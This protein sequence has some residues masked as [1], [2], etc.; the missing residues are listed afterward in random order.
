MME[1]KTKRVLVTG[2]SGF[3]G[4]HLVDR[5]VTLGARVAVVD[6]LEHPERLKRFEGQLTYTAADL[7]D[8]KWEQGE[9]APFEIIFHLAAFSTPSAA[10]RDPQLAYRQNVMATANMLQLA[11]QC[12]VQKFVFSSAGALYTNLPKYLPID[13]Q[14]PIDPCQSVYAMTK[15][16][17][18]LLCE[19]FHR[20]YQVPT[21]YFRLFN[22]YGPLQADHFLI[23]SF[24]REA[25]TKGQVTVLNGAVR[26]D[27]TY[28][29]DTVKAL[30][31]GA[32]SEFCGG[33]INL[34]TGV[35]TS[36]EEIARAIGTSL[37]VEVKL[38]NRQV[39]GPIRQ[40]CDRR[41]AERLLGWEPCYSLEQGLSL[42]LQSAHMP[43]A[44]GGRR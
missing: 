29:S 24:I 30:L 40:L 11:R 27:F 17:G 2:G 28:V 31:L 20:Q 12:G 8:W 41:L 23:P 25:L 14:H 21:V 44:L 32:E 6:C 19:D 39:F 7:A 16:I 4:S 38:L 18:E 42:T 1:W 9:D 15:R 36:V 26:R 3:V 5:L 22:T 33:P 13:E 43:R 35:E 10:Q 34:G 37:G